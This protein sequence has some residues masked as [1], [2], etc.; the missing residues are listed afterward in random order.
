MSTVN[1]LPATP[2]LQSV[3]HD[4]RTAAAT[5]TPIVITPDGPNLVPSMNPL[6]NEA[7]ES[8]M[9]WAGGLNPSD[10]AWCEF[11][12]NAFTGCSKVDIDCV[13]CYFFGSIRRMMHLHAEKYVDGV[14][15][16]FH[17]EALQAPLKRLRPSVIFGP[18]MSDPFHKSFSNEEIEAFFA[19]MRAASWH[20][21]IVLTKRPERMADMV[22]SLHVSENVWLGTSVGSE[23]GRHRIAQLQRTPHPNRVLSLEPLTQALPDLDLRG[24]G[25]VI[26]GGESGNGYRAMDVAWALDIRDQCARAGVPFFFKQYAGVRP[27]SLGRLLDGREHNATPAGVALRHFQ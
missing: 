25:W 5:A 21:F 23:Q 12:W 17:E 9:I 13:N 10:I 2:Q 6:S 4:P 20:T 14:R 11:T 27:S 1:P 15:P 16:V 24:I 19:V 7:V 18:S 22:P 3:S 26:V 8:A